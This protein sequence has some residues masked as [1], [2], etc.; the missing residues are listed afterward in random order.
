MAFRLFRAADPRRYFN[1]TTTKS[2]FNP[3][4]KGQQKAAEDRAKNQKLE[5]DRMQ[6]DVILRT[7]T[8]YLELA[9]VRH[10]LDLIRQRAGERA[11]RFWK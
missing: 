9:K 1:W 2:I 3:L 10:S 11:R 7:A 6:D 4:L 5:I 8:A